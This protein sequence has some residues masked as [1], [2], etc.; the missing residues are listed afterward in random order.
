LFHKEE[1]KNQ[2]TLGTVDLVQQAIKRNCRVSDLF[3]KNNT[4][5]VKAEIMPF[6][7]AN[8]EYGLSCLTDFVPKPNDYV[9]L[10]V[11]L[12]L[13]NNMKLLTKEKRWKGIAKKICPDSLIE[14]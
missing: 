8:I 10:M 13:Q 3:I 12:Y 2:L 5:R 7:K 4:S 11:F 1:L 14:L 9:D 6:I